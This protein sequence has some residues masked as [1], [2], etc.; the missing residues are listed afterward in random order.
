MANYIIK[1]KIK[2]Q[3]EGNKETAALGT[4]LSLIHATQ[5]SILPLNLIY[6]MF[7]T[8]SSID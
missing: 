5:M 3:G 4:V 8:Y 7:K 2:L 6:I 1:K